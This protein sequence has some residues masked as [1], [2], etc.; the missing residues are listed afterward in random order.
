MFFL[1]GLRQSETRPGTIEPDIGLPSGPSGKAG[2][3]E[4]ITTWDRSDSATFARRIAVF[5]AFGLHVPMN[6]ISLVGHHG[7]GFIVACIFSVLNVIC[8]G[9]ALWKIGEWIISCARL[10]EHLLAGW[11]DGVLDDESRGTGA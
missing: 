6:I 3:K 4:Y 5:V 7:V 10:G 1:F 8:V 9:L 11:R 2:F